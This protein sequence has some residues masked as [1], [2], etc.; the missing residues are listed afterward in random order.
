MLYIYIVLAWH[1]D[2]LS[3]MFMEL[4]GW[5]T[6]V[7]LRSWPSGRFYGILVPTFVYP[8]CVYTIASPTIIF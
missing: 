8:N 7:N 1:I 2:P 6:A 5:E 3:S 4:T